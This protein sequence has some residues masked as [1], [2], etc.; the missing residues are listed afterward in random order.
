M[1]VSNLSR[2]II[3]ILFLLVAN[4]I[5][6]QQSFALSCRQG[7]SA[8]SNDPTGTTLANFPIGSVAFAKSDF[9]AGRV[10]WR[11]ETFTSTFTCWDTD[12][13]KSG[14]DAYIYWNPWGDLNTIDPSLTIGV[15]INGR[16][17]DSVN[18][19]YRVR[20]INLGRGTGPG[21][22]SVCTRSFF[23]LCLEFKTYANP[24]T[25]SFSF[26]IYI[27]ASG[28]APPVSFPNI[29]PARVFQVDGQYQINSSTLNGN[30]VA[31]LTNFSNIRIL[32]CTPTIT[33]SGTSA[34]AVNFG[35][36]ASTNAHAGKVEKSIP[37]TVTANIAGGGCSGESLVASFSSPDASGSAPT[38]LVPNN[39]PGVGIF[40]TPQSDTSSKVV[41]G[42]IS[43]FTSTAITKDTTQISKTY[44]A[45]LQWL[46]DR[47][48]I[49]TFSS[50]ATVN[51]TFK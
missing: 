9:V 20:A 50:T 41:F 19:Q 12:S 11:S 22:Y 45:N 30:Y 8:S 16:D 47:P 7:S 25:L 1:K 44:N 13:N 29:S 2:R 31:N 40:I 10:L 23:G 33:I 43:N 35:I 36:L 18:N 28:T 37:F 51:V 14:E 39:Q 6:C 15:T 21:T 26:S 38:L 4:I 49:G 34:N 32:Q 5:C 3:F 42:Q 27:K 46:T 24:S 48:T 17:Y